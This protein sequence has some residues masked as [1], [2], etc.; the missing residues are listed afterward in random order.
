MIRINEKQCREYLNYALN[1]G[2]DFKKMGEIFKK[3]TADQYSAAMTLL[4]NEEISLE[5]LYSV[6]NNTSALTT[7][8][9]SNMI[10]RRLY[11]RDY[12]THLDYKHYK[13]HS[14]IVEQMKIVS[15]ILSDDEKT[16]LLS[17]YPNEELEN[18]LMHFIAINDGTD[19]LSDIEKNNVKSF[20]DDLNDIGYPLLK[21]LTKISNSTLH[22]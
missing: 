16:Y 10:M 9:T 14:N 19:S 15:M 22:N 11:L 13:D 18:I 12:I 4:Y 20:A 21:I 2:S 17:K 5:Q 7:L 3:L 6:I 8:L 1:S